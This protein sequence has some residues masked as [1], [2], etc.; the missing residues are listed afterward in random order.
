M[1]NRW[2]LSPSASGLT[3]VTLTSVVEIGTNPLA[4]LAERA[5][6]RM[7]A[8]QSDVMLDGLKAQVEGQL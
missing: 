7:L 4:H 6:C 1:S 2:T 3:T 8:R 5:V